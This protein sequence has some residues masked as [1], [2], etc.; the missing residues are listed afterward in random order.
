MDFIKLT[1]ET[2]KQLVNWNYYLV[3]FKGEKYP[4]IAQYIFAHFD[5]EDRYY[6]DCYPTNKAEIWQVNIKNPDCEITHFMRLPTKAEILCGK[7][8]NCK[9]A[10][11]YYDSKSAQPHYEPAPT[12]ICEE[13]M[14]K[15]S[16]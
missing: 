8:F 11:T 1:E 6:F 13:C 16:T 5:D 12:K 14:K 15:E 4:L 7:C 10:Y 9:Y 3:L 2:A